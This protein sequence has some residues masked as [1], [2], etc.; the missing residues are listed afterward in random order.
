ML[1]PETIKQTLKTEAKNLGFVLFGCSKHTVLERYERYDAWIEAGFGDGMPYLARPDARRARKDP[2]LLLPGLRT[3][4]SMAA[5]YPLF[6]PKTS[7]QGHNA[8]AY[9]AS[10][11]CNEDY[12]FVLGN[13]AKKLVGQLELWVPG[14]KN[15]VCVDTSPILEKAYAQQAGLGWVGQ[16]TLI[17]NPEYG[18][19]LMLA[20][21]LTSVELPFDQP[22]AGDPCINCGLCLEACPTGAL[23]GERNMDS[24]RCLSYLTIENRAEIP[25]Q[26][27]QALGNRV[28]GC[29]ACQQACPYNQQPFASSTRLPLPAILSPLVELQTELGLNAQEFKAKYSGTPALRAKHFGFLR[30]LII[31]AANSGDQRV[32]PQLRKLKLKYPDPMLQETL[33][34]AINTLEVGSPSS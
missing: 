13:L 7:T 6:I 27:R 32:L 11:A 10:Y 1:D 2:G 34:W 18:S 33:T 8:Y 22:I 5:P 25:A 19:H 9:L 30:N 14:S 29:D 20:E 12:Q 23:L 31:A 21:I 16:N 26:F 15:R 17:F 28:F 3:V 24:R 4:I